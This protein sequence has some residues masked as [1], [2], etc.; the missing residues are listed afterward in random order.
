MKY[1]VDV[2]YPEVKVE[3]PNIEYAKILSNIYAGEVSE[4][5]SINLYIFQHISLSSKYKE[6]ANI[7]RQIAIVEMHHL[8]I[9][10]KLIMLLGMKPVYMSYN[11]SKKGL[12]PWNATYV[13]YSININ[14]IIDADIRAET[15]AIKFYNYI[16]TIIKDKYI[17]NI[18]KRIIMDEEMHLKIFKEYKEKLS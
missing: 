15:N 3:K 6:Y 10:G 11:E 16:L 2:P 5:T 12:V 14:D 4:D 7:L 18:I 1:S 9:L 17:V 13:D 8:D